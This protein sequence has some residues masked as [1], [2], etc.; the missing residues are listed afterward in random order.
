MN[1][2]ERVTTLFSGC[3]S[4]CECAFA[5]LS[6]TVDGAGFVDRWSGTRGEGREFSKEDVLDGLFFSCWDVDDGLTAGRSEW[7]SFRFFSA[8]VT[9]HHEQGIISS[10]GRMRIYC[11]HE[12]LVR[13]KMLSGSESEQSAWTTPR[14]AHVLG[15]G[16]DGTIRP[17]GAALRLGDDGGVETVFPDSP[18]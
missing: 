11:F 14:E 17:A 2:V 4:F 1:A 10:E 5:S 9:Y 7:L 15:E 13:N 16:V 18:S 8:E 3:E 6:N 12:P